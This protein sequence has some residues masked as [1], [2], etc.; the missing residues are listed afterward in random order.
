MSLVTLTSSP[1]LLPWGSS[2]KAIISATNVVG[3]SAFS[4][5][6]NGAV[7]LSVPSEP[8][9]LV[10]VPAVTTDKQIGL[11]WSVPVSAGGTAV[12]DYR[13]Y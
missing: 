8:L 10:N 12:I 9:T 3:Q 1:Y 4:S 2:V 11:A 6:G 5:I 13:I 7:L